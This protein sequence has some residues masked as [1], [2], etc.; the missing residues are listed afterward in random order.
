MFFCFWLRY[1][2]STVPQG[3]N[4]GWTMV[5]EVA[6]VARDDRNGQWCSFWV[7][8]MNCYNV[9]VIFLLWTNSIL[10]NY[11]CELW[12]FMVN[13][14]FEWQEIDVAILPNLSIVKICVY[15]KSSSSWISEPSFFF[16][17]YSHFPIGH[18]LIIIRGAAYQSAVLAVDVD[19]LQP[20]L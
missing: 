16:F 13:D 1:S 4:Q 12:S 20:P 8:N 19:L 15:S 9:L 6:G 11:L 3:K 14:I 2:T 5:V 17:F 7:S 18:Q 10:A